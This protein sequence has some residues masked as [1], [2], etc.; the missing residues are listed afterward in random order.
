[1]ATYIGKRIVPVHCGKWDNTKTYEMLSIVLEETS[2]DSYIAR[3]AVPVGTAITDTHYWMLHS[4]YS[5]QIRDMS[6]QLAATE[7]RIAA[8]NRQTREHVDS[9][10]EETTEA[11]TETVAQARTAMTEQKAEFDAATRQLNTR[12]DA[13]LAGGT[14]DGETEILDARVDS[15]GNEYASLGAAVRRSDAFLSRVP[16]LPFISFYDTAHSDP[17]AGRGSTMTFIR[18]TNCGVP[19]GYEIRLEM[20]NEEHN[21]YHWIRSAF[22]L[23]DNEYFAK[24]DG[25]RM[26]VQI[27][28]P[29]ECDI[30]WGYGFWSAFNSRYTVNVWQTLHPGYNEFIA[31]TG[32]EEYQA[33]ERDGGSRFNLNFLFG[34]Y[35]GH[36]ALEDGVYTFRVSMVPDDEFGYGLL[37]ASGASESFFSAHAITA[38]QAEEAAHAEEAGHASESDFAVNAAHAGD[39]KRAGAMSV[40][41]EAYMALVSQREYFIWDEET[42]EI[43]IRVTS[44]FGIVSDSGFS[45]RL[46]TME[47]LRGSTIIFL[48][49]EVQAFGHVALNAGA[50]WG[51]MTYADITFNHLSGDYYIADFDDLFAQLVSKKSNISEDF[52]GTFWL[53]V[54]GNTEWTLPEEGEEFHNRYG[55]YQ[56]REDS[57]VYSPMLKTLGETVGDHEERIGALEESVPTEQTIRELR[58]RCNELETAIDAATA[59][60]VLWGK[61]YFATGDSFTEGDF[62]GWTDDEGRSGRNS[63]IIYDSEWRMYKTYPWWIARRNNMTL[64]NDGVCGSIMPLSKQYVNGDEGVAQNYRSPFSLNRYRNIPADADYITLWFGINDTS[65]TNL[66]TID[67]AT[68][69]TYYGAWNVVMEYLLTNHPYAKIGIIITDGAGAAYRQATRDIAR[70]WGIPYLDMMG[71]DQ[72]PVIFGRESELGLCS[73]ANTLRRNVFLVGPSNG[74]PNLEAHKY[75]S[76]FVE[77]FLRRL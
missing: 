47:E 77:D 20:N 28:S 61:K 74:H 16:K 71:S 55:V 27:W 67:D 54:Y 31:D 21:P 10:L 62:S 5:Q 51:N 33:K 45:M 73:R 44:E 39:A 60:N 70:K 26:I 13:V 38:E 57:F 41:K 75:Q 59:G 24:L 17:S 25:K 30:F 76:T 46:G 22:Y 18:L 4:L 42:G 3:R 35:S 40:V 58:D 1:M 52:D 43:D 63:P 36:P 37:G 32:S 23:P 53:M 7:Q 50:S 11:L 66:G 34:A 72:T 56:V 12:M 14:G 15:N 9:S 48:R 64:I 65:N 19:S 68:N 2:G 69:E 49:E 29:I 8:D 6:D